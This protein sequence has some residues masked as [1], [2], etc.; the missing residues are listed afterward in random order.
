MTAGSG[1]KKRQGWGETHKLKQNLIGDLYIQHRDRSK[2]WKFLQCTR[3]K[4][5]DLG[6]TSPA[7]CDPPNV[8]SLTA[9]PQIVWTQW[10][11]PGRCLLDLLY[12][13]NNSKG[14]EKKKKKSFG[15]TELCIYLLFL[16][17]GNSK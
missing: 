3:S 10:N 15:I 14:E 11:K 13:Q 12:K 2:C 9:F 6:S 17:I 4:K 7:G 5:W 8:E 16:P 1:L